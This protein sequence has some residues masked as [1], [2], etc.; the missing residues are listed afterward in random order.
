MLNDGTGAHHEKEAAD[1]KEVC[2]IAHAPESK[3]VQ[4]CRCEERAEDGSEAAEEGIEGATT[5]VNK[6]VAKDLVPAR[7]PKFVKGG[8]KPG[9]VE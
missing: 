6:A 5:K 1:A 4:N 7:G 9:F 8:R 3:P 2:A